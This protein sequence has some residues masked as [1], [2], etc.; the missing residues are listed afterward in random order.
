MKITYVEVSDTWVISRVSKE[1]IDE[2]NKIANRFNGQGIKTIVVPDD[3]EIEIG[4]QPK[5]WKTANGIQKIV[6]PISQQYEPIPPAKTHEQKVARDLRHIS[7]TIKMMKDEGSYAVFNQEYMSLDVDKLCELLN[8]SGIK[9]DITSV[10]GDDTVQYKS[11]TIRN[12]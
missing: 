2:A 12:K 7:N 5:T 1:K 11:L 10:Y 6:P 4:S 8:A 9:A 3:F